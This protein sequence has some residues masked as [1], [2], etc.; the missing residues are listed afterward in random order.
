MEDSVEKMD[1]RNRRNE[2]KWFFIG[3][4]LGCLLALVIAVNVY[5]SLEPSKCPEITGVTPTPT[6][7][8]APTP[9]NILSPTPSPMLISEKEFDLFC[10]I[11]AKEAD[12]R[13]GYEGALDVATV[14]MNRTTA[15][16]WGTTITSVVSAPGQFPT[17]KNW[18]WS[19]PQDYEIQAAN[20]VLAGKRSFP[21]YVL[22]F[23]TQKAYDTHDFFHKLVI[24]DKRNGHVFM[25]EKQEIT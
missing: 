23:C 9:T 8:V 11:I 14:I 7:T 12:P 2:T 22:Y 6:T 15:G 17:Y 25:A 3:M 5:L 19:T 20:D 24:I 10:H 16:H 13:W 21:S 1:T 18:D 4:I